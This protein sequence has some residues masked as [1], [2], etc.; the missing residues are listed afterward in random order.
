MGF[1]PPH[2]TEAWWW[3]VVIT[4]F[5]L[6]EFLRIPFGLKNVAQP[7]QRLMDTVLRDLSVLA[8]YLDAILVVPLPSK[9]DAVMD[10]PRP[11]S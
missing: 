6:F 9:V 4:T 5:G 1:T 8:V 3:V 11:H 7:L 2:R 10:F